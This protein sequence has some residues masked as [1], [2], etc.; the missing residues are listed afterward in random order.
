[1]KTFC[2]ALSIAALLTVTGCEK[3]RE[4]TRALTHDDSKFCMTI[5]V[6]LSGSFQQKMAEGGAAHQ[7]CH[8]VL[9]RYFKDRI[10]TEDKLIIAQISGTERALLWQGTPQQLRK[11]FSSPQAFAA[12]LRSKA[13]PGGSLVHESLAR[14]IEYVLSEPNVAN[15][16]AK[17]ALFVLSDMLDTGDRTQAERLGNVMKEFGQHGGIV[18]MYYVDQSLV[19]PWREGLRRAGVKDF[20]VESEIV[21]KPNLPNIE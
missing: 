18:G 13:D 10:G 21:S 15:G 20:A 6:D 17:S 8:E 9:S 19:A 5:V 3:R 14:T 16:T 1:M 11:E 12:F 7:F 2:L 4:S